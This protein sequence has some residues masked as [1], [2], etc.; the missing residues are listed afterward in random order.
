MVPSP[1]DKGAEQMEGNEDHFLAALAEA[2]EN[3][4]WM[5][6]QSFVRQKIDG[7]DAA[8]LEFRQILFRGCQFTGCTFYKASFYDCRFENCR[9]VSCRF[10]GSYFRNAAFEGCRGD[11]ADFRRSHWKNCSVRETILR[12]TNFKQSVW[13]RSEFSDCDFQEAALSEIRMV[14]PVFRRVDFSRADFFRTILRGVDLTSC[15]IDGISLSEACG[16]LRGA[17]IDALQAGVVAGILGIE[18]V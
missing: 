10:E 3:G 15:T 18:V 16:E 6:L 1:A 5:E 7:A 17:R 12:C 13:E 11:G 9:W 8:E 4:D 2:R 14:R